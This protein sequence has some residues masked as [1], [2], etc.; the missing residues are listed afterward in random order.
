MFPRFTLQEE[1]EKLLTLL[2]V[3]GEQV[4]GFAVAGVAVHGVA[5]ADHVNLAKGEEGQ[6]G[7]D[8]GGDGGESE[9]GD[10]GGGPLRVVGSVDVE[11]IDDIKE[12][13]DAGQQT[14]PAK[15]GEGVVSLDGG[16]IGWG[17]A[18]RKM[19]SSWKSELVQMNHKATESVYPRAKT[20][21]A[22][23][24][25]MFWSMVRLVLLE[26][27]EGKTRKLSHAVNLAHPV[28]IQ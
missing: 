13:E 2:L 3:F 27:D 20:M 5:G 8:E 24:P 11:I 26:K 25:A 16:T 12:A 10:G 14:G 23:M 28:M 15:R 18:Y 1:P 19:A 22:T 7:V 17:G 4:D 9:G 21:I 6:H